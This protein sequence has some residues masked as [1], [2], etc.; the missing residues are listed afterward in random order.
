LVGHAAVLLHPARAEGRA[1]TFCPWF[2]LLSSPKNARHGNGARFTPATS[3]TQ[4]LGQVSG[5]NEPSAGSFRFVSLR[6]LGRT[7]A[8]CRQSKRRVNHT[9]RKITLDREAAGSASGSKFVLKAGASTRAPDRSGGEAQPA[10]PETGMSNHQ[11]RTQH[12]T[13]G[14]Y[15]AARGRP[16]PFGLEARPLRDPTFCPPIGVNQTRP[17]KDRSGP[18]VFDRGRTRRCS[19]SVGA[20]FPKAVCRATVN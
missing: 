17:Y 1:L 4:R 5:A 19:G 3:E 12:L 15:F 8:A 16:R 2:V 10:V 7:R 18:P 6:K 11:T 20:R 13:I 14:G 9:T